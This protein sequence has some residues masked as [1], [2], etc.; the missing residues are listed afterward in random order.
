METINI[1]DIE[2]IYGC[3]LTKSIFVD[4]PIENTRFYI[5]KDNV[6]EDENGRFYNGYVYA[7]SPDKRVRCYDMFGNW[8]CSFGSSPLNLDR[9]IELKIRSLRE[10]TSA[11]I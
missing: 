6:G 5:Y 11:H 2:L 9:M 3:D 10:G 1:K 8:R 4:V 7:M